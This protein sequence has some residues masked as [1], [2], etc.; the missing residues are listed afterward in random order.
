MKL[1]SRD[2]FCLHMFV[3]ANVGLL[4]INVCVM[5]ILLYVLYFV[6]YRV[7]HDFRA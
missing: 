3:Y 5:Q 7:F 2:V 1:M 4:K 6:L